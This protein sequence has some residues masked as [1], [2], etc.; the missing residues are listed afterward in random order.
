MADSASTPKMKT[1][2]SVDELIA[3]NDDVRLFDVRS[4]LHDHN[5][6]RDAYQAGHIPKAMFAN[7]ETDLSQQ[8]IAGKTG[9]HPLPNRADFEACVKNW[10]V[11]NTDHVVV[12]DDGPGAFA[13]R[14]WWMFRWLGHYNVSVL[15]GGLNAWLTANQTITT[16]EP[17]F[18]RSDFTAKTAITQL[19]E[20]PEIPHF[21]GIVTD[22]RD[23][24]RFIGDVEPID[25]VAGHI[26]DAIS[27]PFAS[28]LN[29]AGLFKDTNTLKRQFDDASITSTDNIVCYC[30]SGVTAAHNILALVHTG[31]LEPYLYAGSWSEWIVDPQRPIATKPSQ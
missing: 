25:P 1:L 11:K 14:L 18:A 21:N 29:E 19:I 23:Y 15:D 2:I 9:R 10:G 12:Y 28:N 4:A 8:V 16:T 24:P 5:Y 26:P 13:A 7:L 27:L 6:G 31:H 17:T 22:A 30:G 20:A 3:L